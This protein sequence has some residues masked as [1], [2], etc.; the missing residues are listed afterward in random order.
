MVIGVERCT[1]VL[2][3]EQYCP[4]ST[5]CSVHASIPNTESICQLDTELRKHATTMWLSTPV[6]KAFALIMHNSTLAV[7][8]VLCN[9]HRLKY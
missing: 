9:A 1:E 5:A 8:S 4:T 6:I 7:E 3:T 2:L